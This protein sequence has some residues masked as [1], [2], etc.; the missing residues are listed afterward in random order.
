M[1]ERTHCPCGKAS[2]LQGPD[3][4]GVWRCFGCSQL[5]EAK[6]K[7]S[8][9]A[10]GAQ[11]K[12]SAGKK[13]VESARR[14]GKAKKAPERRGGGTRGAQPWGKDLEEFDGSV[15]EGPA[16]GADDGPRPV[17][18]GLDIG[19]PTDRLTATQRIAEQLDAG[20][21]QRST[22]EGMLKAIARAERQGPAD[23]H[24]A[25]LNV[26][27][28]EITSREEADALLAGEFGPTSV[29]ELDA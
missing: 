28:I 5:P 7:K 19:K 2:W 17:F 26:R 13:R 27:F 10:K 4:D 18:E 25:G 14:A 21:L 9:K 12:R 23:E 6:E 1:S 24:G 15:P 11:K 29:L 3:Q 20:T 22:A 8:R 16:A